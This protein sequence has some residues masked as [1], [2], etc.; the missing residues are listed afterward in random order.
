MASSLDA[1]LEK[2]RQGLPDKEPGFADPM[3]ATSSHEI[4]SAP[5]WIYQRKLDGMEGWCSGERKMGPSVFC[6]DSKVVS[7]MI[8]PTLSQG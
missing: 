2:E 3:L 5:D 6:M 4:F 1:S 7:W 8:L